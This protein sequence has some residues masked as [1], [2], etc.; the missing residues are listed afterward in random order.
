MKQSSE[1]NKL[2]EVFKD[3]VDLMLFY[4]TWL[5][6]GM[7]ASKAYKELHPDVTEYSAKTLG[8]RML[9]KVDK[10]LLMS[11]YGLDVDLYMKQ[12]K[13]GV[14]ADERDHFSGEIAP[15]HKTRKGYHDKLGK[16]LGI[17]DDR[18]TQVNILQ[19]GGDMSLEFTK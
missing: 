7:N 18:G 5:K 2:Q 19:Q 12:L 4:V 14:Q 6:C 11:A 1:V 17:E 3:D 16:L 10:S 8:S 15:D 9:Q 13:D